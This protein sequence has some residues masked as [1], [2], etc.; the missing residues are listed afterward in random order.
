MALISRGRLS[1]TGSRCRPRECVAIVCLARG[2]A[3]TRRA[4]G[5]LGD[6]TGVQNHWRT[7]KMSPDNRR[8]S[9]DDRSSLSHFCEGQQVQKW[10]HNLIAPV[11]PS[12]VTSRLTT[13]VIERMPIDMSV[14]QGGSPFPVTLVVQVGQMKGCSWSFPPSAHLLSPALAKR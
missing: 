13:S 11:F 5:R 7:L 10:T 4:R 8:H 6:V 1:V 3:K 9:K 14:F 12:M 2:P